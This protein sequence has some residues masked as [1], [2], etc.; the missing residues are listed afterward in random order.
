MMKKQ[1]LIFGII[2]GFIIMFIG[3]FLKIMHIHF[4][5]MIMLIGL[6]STTILI[7]ILLFLIYKNKKVS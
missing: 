6:F 4:Y 3:L 7:I 5:Q 1:N 2:T